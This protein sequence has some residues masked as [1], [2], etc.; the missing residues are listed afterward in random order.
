MAMEDLRS[1]EDLLDLQD[2]DSQIDRLLDR[3]ATLPELDEYRSAHAEVEALSAR[4]AEAAAQ[5]RELDLASDKASGEIELDQAKL[6]TEELRLYAGGISARDAEH[7]RNEVE[8]LRKRVG[9]REEETL[10]IMEEREQ[11]G[12]AHQALK[13]ELD[14]ATSH[15]TSLDSKIKTL[16]TEI[17]GQVAALEEKKKALVPN[18]DP[19]L[20]ELYEEIRPSKEGVAAVRFTNR[21]C[22]GCHLSLSAAE[23]SQ[24]LKAHPPR[25]M[26]CRRIL[27]PL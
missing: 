2:V 22:G 16:W 19:E 20:L 27:V 18:V 11:V 26:H 17:D 14:A 23:E 7:L 12:G 21:V 10:V 6:E 1:L 3:R 9:D 25:C 5:M 15:K 8:M 4:L 24:A 13:D